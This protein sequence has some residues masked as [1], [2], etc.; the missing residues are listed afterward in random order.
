MTSLNRNTLSFQMGC[1]PTTQKRDITALPLPGVVETV[2]KWMSSKYLRADIPE[3]VYDDNELLMGNPET[4]AVLFYMLNHAVAIVQ[5]KLHPLE[6][7]GKYAKVVHTY[8]EQVALRVPRVFYY[9]LLICTREVRHERSVASGGFWKKMTAK[10]PNVSAFLKNLH[11]KTRP[12]VVEAFREDP[13]SATIG[14]YCAAMVDIFCQGS[15]YDKYGGPAWGKVA[16]ALYSFVRGEFSPELLL[17][18]SFTLAHN[19]APIF[20]KDMLYEQQSSGGS[21]LITILD[22][23]RSGQIPQMVSNNEVLTSY[24]P[25]VK[26]MHQMC[27]LALGSVFEGH[28]D[29]FKV[30]GT[31]GAK[32]KNKYNAYKEKQ[33][34]KYGYPNTLQAKLSKGKVSPTVTEGDVE[35]DK[36]KWVVVVANPTPFMKNKVK[37]LGARP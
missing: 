15:F 27:H 11:G 3:S 23:Q 4:D 7:L 14:E 37:V 1:R 17:D 19:T 30:E 29:W 21:A 35:G 12:Q 22:V 13:P 32:G 16:S 6:D 28:V 8:H 24:R 26:S 10:Y 20:N 31:L 34:A 25:I 36:S 5:S 9:L 33:V 2:N 18:T